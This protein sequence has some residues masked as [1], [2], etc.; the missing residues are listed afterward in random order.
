MEN[1]YNTRKLGKTPLVKGDFS[2]FTNHNTI[3]FPVNFCL[4]DLEFQGPKCKKFSKLAKIEKP[5]P[6][7]N[8]LLI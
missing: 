7:R 2:I 4:L 1:E 6:K 3:L 5:P 8:F